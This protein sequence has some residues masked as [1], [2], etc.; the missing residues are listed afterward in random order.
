MA[1]DLSVSTAKCKA[2][3]APLTSSNG[4]HEELELSSLTTTL[5][6]DIHDLKFEPIWT[7]ATTTKT[8]TTTQTDKLE[9]F[10]NFW[11]VKKT[12]ETDAK[13]TI[14]LFEFEKSN[15][16]WV[17]TKFLLKLQRPVC[18]RSILLEV[19]SILFSVLRW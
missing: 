18:L 16:L 17:L 7:T 6:L 14:K 19:L 9:N 15:I 8:I 11:K 2:Y 5:S 10:V 1:K 3:I 12:F 13:I 4:A